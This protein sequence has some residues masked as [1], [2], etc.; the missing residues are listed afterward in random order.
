MTNISYYFGTRTTAKCFNSFA[1][2]PARRMST[3]VLVVYCVTLTVV[4]FQ[5]N[6]VNGTYRK[7]VFLLG[8]DK[9]CEV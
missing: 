9:L 3:N 4:V 5:A 2:S 6:L 1:N 7:M 8:S